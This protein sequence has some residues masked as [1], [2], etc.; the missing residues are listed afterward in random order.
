MQAAPHGEDRP[1]AGPAPL[2]VAG[3]SGARATRESAADA[4]CA[5]GRAA[6]AAAA[7]AWQR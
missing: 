3:A 6:P 2:P 5:P 4:G 7:R 1:A